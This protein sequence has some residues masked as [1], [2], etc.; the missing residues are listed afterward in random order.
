MGIIARILFIGFLWEK[1]DPRDFWALISLSVSSKSKGTSLKDRLII[2]A[3]FCE[4]IPTRFRGARRNSNPR[5]NFSGEVVK[6][7]REVISIKKISLKA[8][9]DP[10]DKPASVI[11]KGPKVAIG[12]PGVKSRWRRKVNTI[13]QPKGIRPRSTNITESLAR[14]TMVNKNTARRQ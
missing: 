1:S 6:V 11:L 3:I 10:R 7:R 5:L 13:I 4:E 12:A 14:R 8:M 2:I 9:K